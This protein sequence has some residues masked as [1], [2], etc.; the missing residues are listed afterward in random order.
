MEAGG[1]GLQSYLWPQPTGGLSEW[2]TL[3]YIETTKGKLDQRS[4]GV[5]DVWLSGV[6]K[7]GR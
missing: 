7:P 5:E 6:Q 1:S 3:D 2:T 4:P